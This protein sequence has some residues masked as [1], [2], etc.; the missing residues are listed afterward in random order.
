M[1]LSATYFVRMCFDFFSYYALQANT[2]SAG[3]YPEDFNMF[4]DKQMLFKVEVSRGNVNYGWRNYAVKKATDE[5]DII[6]HFLAKHNIQ[7]KSFA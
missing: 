1:L 4:I 2:N 6:Q 5:P 7:V 3:D